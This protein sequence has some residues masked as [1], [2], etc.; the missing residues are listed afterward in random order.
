M[1]AVDITVLVTVDKYKKKF[2]TTRT[3]PPGAFE[4]PVF[5]YFTTPYLI[6]KFLRLYKA[7]I[8]VSKY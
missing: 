8:S 2:Y 7:K 4:T 1:P 5:S 6:P 3:V